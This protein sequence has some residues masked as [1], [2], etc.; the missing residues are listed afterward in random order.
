MAQ[1]KVAAGECTARAD[2]IYGGYQPELPQWITV[3]SMNMNEHRADS[4]LP[5]TLNIVHTDLVTPQV[6]DTVSYLAC[7]FTQ[8]NTS[9]LEHESGQILPVNSSSHSHDLLKG[10]RWSCSLHCT[11]AMQGQQACSNALKRAQPYLQDVTRMMK[12][13]GGTQQCSLSNVLSKLCSQQCSPMHPPN[14]RKV[15][16]KLNCPVDLFCSSSKAQ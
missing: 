14:A 5:Y 7:L 13:C 2:A 12:Q 8:N 4:S 16:R 15:V 9:R 3:P 1:R 10:P 11:T 6:N